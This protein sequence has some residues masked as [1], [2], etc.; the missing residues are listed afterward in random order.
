MNIWVGYVIDYSGEKRGQHSTLTIPRLALNTKETTAQASQVSYLKL[1]MYLPSPGQA[2]LHSN[3][4]F[5]A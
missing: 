2:K 4:T 1:H 5:I 3:L